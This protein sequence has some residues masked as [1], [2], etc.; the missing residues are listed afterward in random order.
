VIAGDT[1]S[2][3][4]AQSFLLARYQPDG[5]LDPTFGDSGRVATQFPSSIAS[6]STSVAVQTDGE[7]VQ[8]GWAE[9]HGSYRFALAKFTA[10]G[11][12]DSTFGAGGLV[13]TAF[14]NGDAWS[15]DLAIQSDDRVVVDGWL[16]RSP[17]GGWALA[18]YNPDGSLDQSF[19]YHGW[20]D[21]A[22]GGGAVAHAIAI[23][24]DGKIVAAGVASETDCGTGN[25]FA[26]VLA[27]YLA[28]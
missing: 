15:E 10:A 5:T 23:Q 19:G 13:T 27:R 28:E 18:R 22:F 1:W 11:E 21:T 16:F 8:A 26:I 2:T 14:R 12:L 9:I 17:D 25:C 6:L 7:I 3:G 20:V 24:P 4:T